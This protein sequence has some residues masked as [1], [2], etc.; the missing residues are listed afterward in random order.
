M[1]MKRDPPLAPPLSTRP[2]AAHDPNSTHDKLLCSAAVPLDTERLEHHD[3]S[4]KDEH[5]RPT[6]GLSQTPS[7]ALFHCPQILRKE[8]SV[9]DN[10]TPPS[11]RHPS[12]C[13]KCLFACAVSCI[14]RHHS[15]DSHRSKLSG[16]CCPFNVARP[17]CVSVV[18]DV[19][20][21]V[22]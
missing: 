16:V 17:R 8:R 22:R 3:R 10:S 6:R 14:S 20:Q 19:L 15:H 5:K 9:P 13:P 12:R 4:I 11:C 7:Q 18:L 1:W 21:G 2:L